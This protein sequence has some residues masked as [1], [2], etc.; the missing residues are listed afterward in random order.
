M[1]THPIFESDFDCLTEPKWK[2]GDPVAT[3]VAAAAPAT[4]ATATSVQQDES[5]IVRGHPFNVGPRYRVADSIGE[6]A[7][8]VV[9]RAQD[10]E[11]A[12]DADNLV[13]IKKISPF[14]HQ[15]Y[16]Q[17][18][19]REIKILL[20]FNH[21]NIIGVRDIKRAD[22]IEDMEHLYIVQEY[23]ETDMFR[24]LRTQ[25][26]SNEHIC[27]FLYQ[28]L[29]GLKYIHSANVIHRDLKIIDFGLARVADLGNDAPVYTEY[30]ATRWYRA[31]EVMLN[32]RSYSVSMDMWSVGCILAEMIQNRPL[33]PGRHYLDQ[34]NLILDVVGTPPQ[35]QMAW[36][37]NQRAREY[38]EALARRAGLDFAELFPTASEDCLDLLRKLLDFN[39]N[40]RINVNDALAHPYLRQYYDPE[41]E[42]VAEQPFRFDE[43]FDDYDRERLKQMIFDATEPS[44]FR[45]RQQQ[46]NQPME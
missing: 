14:D 13:A 40:S 9:V 42:P 24:L 2:M 20:H 32:S 28:I 38:V 12:A 37:A 18:T 6:G 15:T 5:Q 31:P 29:R 22:R 36:I 19:L 39:P 46:M 11:G 44:Q 27:Y 23:M 33:F 21:E 34:L 1:G 16:C 26:I 8:G 3:A 25:P 35:N 41:D 10:T 7:Y 17:R 30:V 43:E 45:I 4:T